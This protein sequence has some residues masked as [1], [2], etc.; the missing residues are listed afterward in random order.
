MK[1]I[2]ALSF[3]LDRHFAEQAQDHRNVMRREGP[4]NVLLAADFPEIQSVRINVLD[5]AQLSGL[6]ERV[7]F[8]NGRMVPEKMADHKNAVTPASEIDQ[9]LAFG[10]RKTEWFFNK[11]VFSS[12]NGLPYQR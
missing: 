5:S 2:P 7:Q 10:H 8:Q 12:Q 11:H 6:D 1:I 3:H 4:Q 9:F